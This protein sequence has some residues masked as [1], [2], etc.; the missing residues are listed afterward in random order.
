MSQTVVTD[1]DRSS[2]QSDEA[3]LSEK[4]AT[5]FSQAQVARRCDQQPLAWCRRLRRHSVQPGYPGCK[6]MVA[7][8]SLSCRWPEPPPFLLMT[9]R[10]RLEDGELDSSDEPKRSRRHA[11]VRALSEPDLAGYG[12]DGSGSSETCVSLESDSGSDSPE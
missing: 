5:G 12:M 8:S 9:E 4:E 3:R 11:R 7:A 6:T 1:N 2:C 10:L